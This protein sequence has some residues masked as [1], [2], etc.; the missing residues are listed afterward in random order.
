MTWICYSVLATS[1][2]NT[3]K[4]IHKG[5]YRLI[6]TFAGATIGALLCK[7]IFEPYLKTM[8]LGYLIMLIGFPFIFVQYA[9]YITFSTTL[10]AASFYLIKTDITFYQFIIARIIDTIIGVGIGILGEIFIFPEKH[11]PYIKQ[12][13]KIFKI[14][15]K[16]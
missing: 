14:N 9:I 2:A 6:G 12:I 5:I 11:S 3:T 15:H 10:I 13:L 4:S 7:F 1:Q 16:S 8:Y